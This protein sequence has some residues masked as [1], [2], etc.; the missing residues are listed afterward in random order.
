MLARISLFE[1]SN[2]DSKRTP[3]VS[4]E[5]ISAEFQIGPVS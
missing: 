5:I 1:K 2:K 4:A 3:S